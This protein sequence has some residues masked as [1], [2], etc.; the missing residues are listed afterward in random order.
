ME[1][2]QSIEELKQDARLFA[3]RNPDYVNTLRQGEDLND[4]DV[5]MRIYLRS[6]MMYKILPAA[7]IYELENQNGDTG[8]MARLLAGH[9]AVIQQ[10]DELLDAIRENR[11]RKE[12]G[13]SF[14][15]GLFRW[16]E[17]A[18]IC[19]FVPPKKVRRYFEQ[20]CSEGKEGWI[21][22]PQCISR[23]AVKSALYYALESAK[24]PAADPEQLRRTRI[25][26]SWTFWRFASIPVKLG[27][28][29]LMWRTYCLR[30]TRQMLLWQKQ[31]C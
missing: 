19:A 10:R 25:L 22:D 8:E 6:G 18:D 5:Q 30:R 13:M 21:Y 20:W 7:L 9:L 2:Y 26:L 14:S 12:A 23:R 28:L 16:E 1:R 3:L 17:L 29:T 11:S 24:D 27:L 15:A 4:P 31:S